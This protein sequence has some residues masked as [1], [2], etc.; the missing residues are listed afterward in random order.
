MRINKELKLEILK[1]R[2]ETGGR[3]SIA[4]KLEL[5]LSAVNRVLA[6]YKSVDEFL[7]EQK[8][9]KDNESLFIE[10]VK[11][12][13]FKNKES[14][15]KTM[16]ELNC[17]REAINKAL[18]H[19]NIKPISMYDQAIKNSKLGNDISKYFNEY[20]PHTCYVLGVILGDGCVHN[21]SSTNKY[22]L[23]VTAEDKDIIDSVNIYFNNSHETQFNKRNNA[24]MIN[25]W[26]KK[27]VELL[28]TKY[29][30][31]GEKAHNLP[32]LELP[33]D[34]YKYFISG[35]HAT[36]GSIYVLKRSNIIQWNYTTVCYDFISKL[37]SKLEEL[38]PTLSTRPIKTRTHKSGAKSYSVT[39]S[40]KDTIKIC[41]WMYEN[42]L[43][44][45]RCE[46]KYQ[47]Y[48]EWKDHKFHH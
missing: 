19:L 1:L 46:R 13:Y 35:L 29:G 3:S 10:K 5:S 8:I 26:S 33:K 2:E 27:L 28:H 30:L 42:T 38:V 32:W 44:I 18:L 20:T 4:K 11:I 12:S 36:D 9:N 39:Y 7:L 17:S 43:P 24:Y 31:K 21:N 23:N 6:D 22:Y 47:K 40:G 16:K 15:R 45:L 14:I 37:K 25:I 48:L 41:N 34:M